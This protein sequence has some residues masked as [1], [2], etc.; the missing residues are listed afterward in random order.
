MNY[1]ILSELE[2]NLMDVFCS[3]GGAVPCP[4]T[5][6]GNCGCTDVA[7][8]TFQTTSSVM[9]TCGDLE[10]MRPNKR[11]KLCKREKN[12]RTTCRVST[13]ISFV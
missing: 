2:S 11:N 1:G 13:Y 5:C 4:S 10:A 3:N 6:A 8:N 9:M 7:T 12:A